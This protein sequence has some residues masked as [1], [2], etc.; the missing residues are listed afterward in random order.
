MSFESL[1]P[2]LL[3]GTVIMELFSFEDDSITPCFFPLRQFELFLSHTDHNID[4]N[5]LGKST[6]ETKDVE[7][8]HEQ[9]AISKIKI[10]RHVMTRTQ[11]KKY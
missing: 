11:Y 5:T 4:E 10:N 1:G 9:F 6:W 7:P 2:A 3:Q 8:A